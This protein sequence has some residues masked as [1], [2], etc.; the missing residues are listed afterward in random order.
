MCF[1]LIFVCDFSMFTQIR[2]NLIEIGRLYPPVS[3][4][5][6][7]L[8]T[9]EQKTVK[10]LKELTTCTEHL[11]EFTTILEGLQKRIQVQRYY[12]LLL[13]YFFSLFIICGFK[14][15]SVQF[16]GNISVKL[17]T[18]CYFVRQNFH[19]LSGY[20]RNERSVQMLRLSA[21]KFSNRA[22]MFFSQFLQCQSIFYQLGSV[23][24]A[25]E[26]KKN[27]QTTLLY[28]KK[29]E[30]DGK[31]V[32]KHFCPETCFPCPDLFACYHIQKPDTSF[33]TF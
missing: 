16:S 6:L 18:I 17:E 14:T 27:N 11:F 25:F 21:F 9:D 3:I 24:S 28:L 12:V 31:K 1:H 15:I 2:I 7:E 5:W 26:F 30:A 4:V 33:Q 8:F 32:C 23:V 19:K 22:A 20:M 13:N 10:L 29:V